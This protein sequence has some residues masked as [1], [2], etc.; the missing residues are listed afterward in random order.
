MSERGIGKLQEVER[1]RLGT[2]D[3]V[4]KEFDQLPT[5][6]GGKT[7]PLQE[8]KFVETDTKQFWAQMESKSKTALNFKPAANESEQ[9]ALLFNDP[10]KNTEKLKMN[11]VH[12][13]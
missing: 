8:P 4:M 13:A 11:Q 10:G 2:A 3:L 6:F 12:A 9:F 7:G 1:P 5:L